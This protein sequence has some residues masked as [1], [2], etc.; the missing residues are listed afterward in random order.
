MGGGLVGGCGR[1][2]RRG[3]LW[4]AGENA[5]VSSW[6]SSKRARRVV[7]MR[8]RTPGRSS[9]MVDDECCGMQVVDGDKLQQWWVVRGSVV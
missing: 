2:G 1:Q 6:W 3:A 9:W 4:V 7:R 8:R 5:R